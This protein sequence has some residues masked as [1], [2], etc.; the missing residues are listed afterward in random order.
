MPS[1]LA[2]EQLSLCFKFGYGTWKLDILMDLR[3]ITTHVTSAYIKEVY[4]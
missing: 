2:L 1:Y 4:V 3:M